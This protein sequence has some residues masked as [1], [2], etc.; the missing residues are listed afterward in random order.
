MAAAQRPSAPTTWLSVN[1][2]R[3]IVG[4]GTASQNGVTMSA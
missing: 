2:L 3:M 1:V 4:V